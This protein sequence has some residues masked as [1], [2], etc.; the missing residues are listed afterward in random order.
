LT[1]LPESGQLAVLFDS[2]CG[3]C[4]WSVAW[5]L[6]LD[7]LRALAPIAIQS[8]RG[9]RL[10]EAVPEAIRLDSAHAVGSD[11]R[12]FSGGDAAPVIANRLRGGKAF[13]PLLKISPALTRAAYRAVATN[14]QSV[15]R[16]VP[17]SSRAS[18]DRLLASRMG[19]DG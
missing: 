4:R 3:F 7:Q 8:E 18:A 1:Q 5:L 19:T 11:G 16:F 13:S 17:A 6:R 9:Q 15:G 12:V 2:D 10:L 14:R